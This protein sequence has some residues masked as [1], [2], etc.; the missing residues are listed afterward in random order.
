MKGRVVKRN[1]QIRIGEF[2]FTV[3]GVTP[4]GKKGIVNSKTYVQCN[5]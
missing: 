1:S 2:S 3:T 5:E 4:S